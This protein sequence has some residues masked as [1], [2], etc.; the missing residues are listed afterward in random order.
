MTTGMSPLMQNQIN[1]RNK[2]HDAMY[3]KMKTQEPVVRPNAQKAYMVKENVFQSAA[4]AVNDNI[5]DIQ[6]FKEVI[7]TGKISDN[8]LGRLN[9]LGLKLGA[10]LIATF[11]A[12]HSKTKQESVMRFVGGAA[13]IASMNLWSKLFIYLPAKLIHGVNPGEKYISAQGDKKEYWIDNQFLPDIRGPKT[14]QEKRHDQKVALQSRTLNMATAGPAVPLMTA[15]I[16]DRVKGPIL[17]GMQALD[18]NK[19]EKHFENGQSLEK[20]LESST[21]IV[22]H[23]KEIDALFE[24]YQGKEFDSDFYKKLADYLRLDDIQFKD[25]DFMKPL[26]GFNPLSLPEVL[27]ETW[28][29][30]VKLEDNTETLREMLKTFEYTDAFTGE[31]QHLTNDQIEEVLKI[32]NGR[33]VEKMKMNKALGYLSQNLETSQMKTMA[34]KMLNAMEPDGAKEIFVSSLGSLSEDE[35]KELYKEITGSIDDFN[36]ATF[37]GFLRKADPSKIKTVFDNRLANY[38]DDKIKELLPKLFDKT[39]FEQAKLA[40]NESAQTLGATQKEVLQNVVSNV[41]VTIKDA[42]RIIPEI[43]ENMTDEVCQN[44]KVFEETLS[45]LKADKSAFKQI[46]DEHNQEIVSTAR[47]RVKA[48][49]KDLNNVIGE[50]AESSAT[51]LHNE[52]LKKLF[53]SFNIPIGKNGTEGMTLYN[54]R[55]KNSQECQNLLSGFFNNKAKGVEFGSEEYKKLMQEFTP[56]DVP[57]KLKECAERIADMENASRIQQIGLDGEQGALQKSIFGEN[58]AGNIANV[59]SG[60]VKNQIMNLQSTLSMGGIALN[61]ETRL[62]NGLIKVH[63]QDIRENPSLLKAAR[64]IIYNRATVKT[65]AQ[66]TEKFTYNDVFRAIFD[67]KAFENEPEVVKTHVNMLKSYFATPSDFKASQEGFINSDFIKRVGDYAARAYNDRSWVKKFGTIGIGILGVTLVA[68]LFFG[69]I[70]K[71]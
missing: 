29:S 48:Y 11:L 19:A 67:D 53:K 8:N 64:K 13:F 61:F 22:K 5:K 32:F 36:S 46:I 14:E 27:E 58:G 60:Y 30:E 41:S 70:K 37:S 7:K 56:L 38:S 49:L 63:G 50:T 43:V 10:G 65:D 47:G 20:Y 31:A 39:D 57:D 6:N 2:A 15:F 12:L 59:L 28:K 71:F 24:A 3:E 25:P 45:R 62:N 1:M 23:Q 42:Q 40:I 51:N 55:S 18:F 68:Q 34:S 33:Y 9:D 16:C 66:V 69:N 35:Q 21:P 44:N 54:L 52:Y 26:N 4:S 17:K